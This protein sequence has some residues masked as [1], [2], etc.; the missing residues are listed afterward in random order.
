MTRHCARVTALG[1]LN[2][3]ERMT[4]ALRFA[5]FDEE[6]LYDDK[7]LVLVLFSRWVEPYVKELRQHHERCFVNFSELAVEWDLR[8]SSESR[9]HG[10]KLAIRK[11]GIFG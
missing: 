9:V 4:I 11:R 10:R 7:G 2:F 8:L 1:I 6:M 5:V 3:Y